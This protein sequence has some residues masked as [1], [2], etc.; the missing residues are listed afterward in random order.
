MSGTQSYYWYSLSTQSV[1]LADE[2]PGED[3]IGPF[4]TAQEAEESP[5]ILLEHARAWLESEESEP[6]R[7]MAAENDDSADY[8]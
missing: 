7:A 5:A 4:S 8:V 6:F 1:V 3:T 2:R